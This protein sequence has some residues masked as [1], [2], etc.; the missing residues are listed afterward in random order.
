MPFNFVPI[1]KFLDCFSTFFTP[2][3][4]SRLQKLTRILAF[5]YLI[6]STFLKAQL[7]QQIQTI[8]NQFDLMGGVVVLFC[9]DSIAYHIPFGW[10]DYGRQIP[11]TDS[12]VFRVASISK[13]VT[14]I[15]YMKLVDQGLANLDEDISNIL[16]YTVRNPFYPNQPITARMLLSH[17]SSIIDGSTYSNF[18]NA[19]ISQNPIPS[20]SEILTPGGAYYSTSNYNNVLPGTYFNYSNLNYVILGTV[21]EKIT[22]RRFDEYM[23]DSVL[24]PSGVD[25]SYNVSHISNID[26]VA[27]L[28]RKINGNWVPQADNYQGIPPNFNNLTGYVPGTNGG[29]FSP[30][31]GLRCSGK[32]LSR[33]FQLLLNAGQAVGTT[34]L[35][36]S[37]VQ[38]MLADTWTYNGNNGN[39]YYDLFNSFG[40]GIHRALGLPGKD[41]VLP[42][43]SIMFGHPGEAY[44]L[45]SDAYVDTT[46]RLGLI[47]ITNGSGTGYQVSSN[48]AYYTVERAV[49][50]VLAPYANVMNCIKL[51]HTPQYEEYSFTLHPNPAD[52]FVV[53]S[54]LKGLG[55]TFSY[56]LF[57][58]Q[59][60]LVRTGII[61]NT[62]YAL[63]VS[64]LPAGVYILS[65]QEKT[66][67]LR[68]RLVKK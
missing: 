14:A 31:G 46:R 67:P 26:R 48:S 36:A 58:I 63:S 68:L 28:Y 25:G 9:Q 16:G 11:V 34:V 49:F 22:G 57:T 2:F 55:E 64:D 1:H 8:R 47:F 60:Q 13:S 51:T 43:S 10:A 5:C 21:M 33:L 24:L 35:S 41:V 27:V 19:T 45:V 53:L 61:R 40:L 3:Q 38:Q 44:G 17:T 4:L 50:D 42:S 39:N 65:L 20:L 23:R 29:R 56:H 54:V 7:S 59:G 62:D 6:P 32:D 12:T 66:K 30:H 18:L 37:A 52:D 15:G